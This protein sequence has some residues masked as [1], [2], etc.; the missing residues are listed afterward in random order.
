VRCETAHDGTM[1]DERR[2]WEVLC[3][4]VGQHALGCAVD[5]TNNAIFDALTE[6]VDA[7]IDVFG[8]VVC[9]RVLAHH[10]TA[11]IVLVEGSGCCLLVSCFSQDL[12]Q[13]HDVI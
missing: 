7:I 6:C 3:E 13:E 5:E 12:T 10:A 9:D 2:S 8:P 4:D 1:A 11:T